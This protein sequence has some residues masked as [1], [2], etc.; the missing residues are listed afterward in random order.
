MVTYTAGTVRPTR[1]PA[2]S[3]VK[4]GNAETHPSHKLCV[5][6]GLFFCRECACY[7]TKKLENLAK[8]CDPTKGKGLDAANRK[9]SAAISLLQGKLPRGVAAFPNS[10]EKILQL[11]D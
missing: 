11:A 1:F 6:K 3:K 7:A 8:P 4:V 9:R 5:H 2:G 10:A